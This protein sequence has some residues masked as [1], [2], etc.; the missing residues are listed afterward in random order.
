MLVKFA[1]RHLV[2]H[3]RMH[4]AVLLGMV[5]CGALLA[6]LP[7]CAAAIA[8]DGLSESLHEAFAFVRNVE[9]RGGR[10]SDAERVQLYSTLGAHVRADYELREALVDAER[11]V[12]DAEHGLRRVDE[13]LFLRLWSIPLA[14]QVSIVAGRLPGTEPVGTTEGREILEAAV[15]TL[16]QEQFDLAI[17]DELVLEK[18]PYRVRVVGVVGPRD[19]DSDLWW[20][21]P[22]LLPFNVE[23]QP[24]NQVDNLYLSLILS[25]QTMEA[26]I[27]QSER[28]WRVLLNWEAIG[29]DNAQLVRDHLVELKAHLSA[30]GAEARTGLITLLDRYRSQLR[31]GRISLLLLTA[32]SLL[33]AL[34]VLGTVSAFLVDRSGIEFGSM[35][36]RGFGEWQLTLLLGS[37]M[38]LLAVPAVPAGPLL[39]HSVFRAWSALTGRPAAHQLPPEVWWLSAIAV[40]GAWLSLLIAAHFACKRGLLQQLRQ[41]GR[42]A[43][44]SPWQQLTIDAFLLTL[45]GLAYWQLRQ[46]G[47]FVR[48]ARGLDSV[49]VDPVLLLGPSLFLLALGLVFIRAFPVV[50]RLLGHLAQR[51]RNLVLPLGIVRLARQVGRASQVTLLITL[52]TALVFFATVFRDSIVKRQQEVA[53]Y[54]T[55]ADVRVALPASE[56][57]AVA[58][59]ARIEALAGV[60]AAADTFRNQARWSPFR[61]AVVNTQTVSFLAVD[62]DRFGQV[63]RYPPGIGSAEMDKLMAALAQRSSDAVPILVSFDAP[64]GSD[65][66]CTKHARSNSGY[67]PGR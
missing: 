5:L 37:E 10:L 38:A 13:V 16:A 19:A 3:W 40:A 15:G 24:T 23:R 52:T 49:A 20:S 18:A 61:V 25:P 34:Y 55:G 63:A 58:Q 41:R 48:E 26:R 7:L 8:G 29:V 46:T 14:D 47:T 51:A 57:A 31:L 60:T 30:S 22:L 54:I 43:E 12:Y 64:P 56:P 2:R 1:L 36:A 39:A 35:A 44:A 45:G 17:G 67:G 9:V 42:P 4:L 28:Y 53:H 59:A 33:A 65:H 62:R 66:R 21:D 27:P 6:S 11:A 32:Q 50:L